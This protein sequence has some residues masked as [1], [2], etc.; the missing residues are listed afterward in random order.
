MLFFFLRAS[1]WILRIPGSL[2]APGLLRAP[3]ACSVL[4][5]TH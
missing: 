4:L 5:V 1:V 2:Q 3:L